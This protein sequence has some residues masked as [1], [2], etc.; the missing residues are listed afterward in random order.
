[1]AIL[2]DGKKLREKKY[3]EIV[4]R[5][6][7]LKN[8]GITP[9]LAVVQVGNDM[10]SSI[11]IKHKENACK[12]MGINFTKINLEDSISYKKLKDEVAKLNEN[13]LIHGIIIQFPLPKQLTDKNI[14]AL[15]D[16]WKDA[17]GIHPFNQ[18]VHMTRVNTYAPKSCTPNGI[19]EFFKEY[20]IDLEGKHVVVVG[21][22][23]IVGRP[24]AYLMA[25]ENATL[26]LLHSR[27]T[28]IDFHAEIQVADIIILATG[29][30]DII[31]PDMVKQDVII[32]DVGI[33]KTSEG[34]LR[35]DVLY[36]DFMDKASYITPVPGGVGPMTVTMLIINVVELAEKSIKRK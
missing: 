14:N 23:N 28:K 1:M 36:K 25:N 6:S 30:Q 21:R 27:T 18:G 7:N 3:S 29:Q 20:K 13:P 24:I 34:R 10:A 5:V 19:M 16:V 12:N 35:G 31:T 4:K 11:Y 32:I 26:S 33:T 17:D 9:H 2:L 22:S 8:K 15:V